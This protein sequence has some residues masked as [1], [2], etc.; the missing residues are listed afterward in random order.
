MSC[1]ISPFNSF[2][3]GPALK[4]AAGSWEHHLII[5]PYN[6]I[7]TSL[8]PANVE[9]MGGKIDKDFRIW[10]ELASRK[11]KCQRCENAILKGVMFVRMGKKEKAKTSASMCA[12]CFE[13]VMSELSDEFQGFKEMA[14]AST[15]EA[16]PEEPAHVDA[17]PHCFGCGLVPEKCRCAWEA[18]R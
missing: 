11:R 10:V 5:I 12:P 17:G 16:V 14:V 9:P 4:Q 18:Y 7:G 2:S 3:L 13:L 6:R 1:I 8:N 15:K